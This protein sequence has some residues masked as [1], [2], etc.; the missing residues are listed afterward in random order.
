VTTAA[1]TT[2]G[3]RSSIQPSRQVT[4]HGEQEPMT[5]PQPAAPGLAD[6]IDP[7]DE[8]GDAFIDGPGVVEDADIEGRSLSLFEGDEGTLTYEQRCT[9]VFLLKHR[10]ISAEQHPAEWRTLIGAQVQLRSRLNDLF[11]D[12]H[13]DAYAQ[14]AFKRQ[15]VPEGDGRFPTLLHDI[16]HTR[17]E[18]ILLIFLRQRFRSERADG[19]DAVLIDRE[20]LLDAVAR[21]RPPDANDRSGDARKVENAILSLQRSGILLRTGDEQRLRVAPVIDVVLPLPRLQELLDTLLSLNGKPP[22]GGSGGPGRAAGLDL[23]LTGAPAPGAGPGEDL[24]WLDAAA[25]G[26]STAGERG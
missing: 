19:A 6:S 25:D 2:Y 7:G 18:T 12:L 5:V 20:E 1:D 14:I 21:F 4:E 3:D 8:S 9:L 17:E 24:G 15:A 10:Y 11:L 16:A 26:T 23:D 13:I 22:A